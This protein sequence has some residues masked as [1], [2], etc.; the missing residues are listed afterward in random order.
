MDEMAT[1]IQTIEDA[2]SGGASLEEV[3][4]THNLK[5]V[6]T[7]HL[8]ADAK[9]LQKGLQDHMLKTAFEQEV[10]ET[11]PVVE[12]E[13][14]MAYVVRVDRVDASV[15]PPSP[16]LRALCANILEKRVQEALEKKIDRLN[17]GTMPAS[18][19]KASQGCNRSVHQTSFHEFHRL[20]GSS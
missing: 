7:A 12:L 6:H 1:L 8:A 19:I 4:K 9:K 15:L 3:A 5:G 10:D 14:G 17:E 11:G 20:Q 18:H 13:D 16:L 2:I